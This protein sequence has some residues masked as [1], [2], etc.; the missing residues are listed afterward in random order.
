MKFIKLLISVLLCAT[1]L[2]PTAISSLA[3]GEEIDNSPT[4]EEHAGGE[5]TVSLEP[6][7]GVEGEESRSCTVCGEQ[8]SR[9][10]PALV[11]PDY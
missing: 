1:L 10:V 5:W 7:Y 11:F 6:D 3:D 2:L 4:C 9:S 8:E